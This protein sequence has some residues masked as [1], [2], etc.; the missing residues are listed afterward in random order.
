MFILSYTTI[1]VFVKRFIFSNVYI[2]VYTIVA[3]QLSTYATGGILGSCKVSS[4][5]L[6]LR[7][8]KA[9][10]LSFHLLNYFRTCGFRGVTPGF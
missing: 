5:D 2:S 10:Y 7:I 9:V 8:F 4:W 6:R 1:Y 3:C